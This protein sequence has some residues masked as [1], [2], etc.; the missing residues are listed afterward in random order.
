MLIKVLPKLIKDV[1]LRRVQRWLLPPTPG[2]IQSSTD[3]VFIDSLVAQFLWKGRAIS[4]Y[5]LVVY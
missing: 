1:L 2:Q 4:K 3:Y 5:P